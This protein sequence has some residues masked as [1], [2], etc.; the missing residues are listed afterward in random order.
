MRIELRV[1]CN[2][3]DVPRVVKFQPDFAVAS[4]ISAPKIVTVIAS[5]GLRYKM[6]VGLL[7]WTSEDYDLLIRFLGER[8]QR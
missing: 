5:N 3:S 6:L 1:D 4:G 7:A 8:R 2:Y